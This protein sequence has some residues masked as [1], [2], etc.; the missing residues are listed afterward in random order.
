MR[1]F[2]QQLFMLSIH[3]HSLV[4]HIFSLN[5]CIHCTQNF[6]LTQFT[7]NLIDI[8]LLVFQLPVNALTCLI[9]YV[10]YS[11]NLTNKWYWGK[12]KFLVLVILSIFY[13]F[14]Q[15]STQHKEL[16]SCSVTSDSFVGALYGWC[17]VN[18][19]L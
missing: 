11:H 3:R 9:R 19:S 4:L 13:K 15:P 5:I 16:H 10:I 8:L 18:Y 6:N 2:S 7:S 1:N 12:R 14:G 17:T